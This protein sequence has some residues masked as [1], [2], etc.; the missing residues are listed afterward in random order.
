VEDLLGDVDLLLVSPSLGEVR[1]KESLAALRGA[2]ER[3]R[4]PVLA[5]SSAVEEGLFADEVAGAVARR[6]RGLAHA[7]E[8]ALGGKAQIEP[9]V[10]ANPVGEAALP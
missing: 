8:V 2:E 5:F 6:D 7:I 1:R 9:G 3:R 4:T 10:V